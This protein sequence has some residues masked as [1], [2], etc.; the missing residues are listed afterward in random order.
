M[1]CTVG[2]GVH[3]RFPCLNKIGQRR[4]VSV[5][6]SQNLI[7]NLTKVPHSWSPNQREWRSAEIRNFTALPKWHWTLRACLS[8]S[9]GKRY[10]VCFALSPGTLAV[11]DQR[12]YTCTGNGMCSRALSY[13]YKV[14]TSLWLLIYH[15]SEFFFFFLGPHLWH[16]V[17]PRLGVESLL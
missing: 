16:M 1:C 7:S 3:T 2:R 12:A 8:P 17:V 15:L 10:P 14:A 11:K 9:S 13:D 4:V 6:L 5:C